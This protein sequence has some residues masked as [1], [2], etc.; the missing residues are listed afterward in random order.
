MAGFSRFKS[1]IPADFTVTIQYNDLISS[2]QTTER[3]HL[4]QFPKYILKPK[5]RPE[6]VKW[7]I[8]FIN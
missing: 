8:E 4:E 5:V 2:N 7:I 1:I 3:L 6:Q